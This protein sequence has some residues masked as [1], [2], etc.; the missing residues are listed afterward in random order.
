M[1]IR[2]YIF[3]GALLIAAAIIVYIGIYPRIKRRRRKR[4]MQTSFPTEWQS[5]LINDFPLYQMLPAPVQNNL[6]EKILVFLAEKNFVGCNGL[7]LTLQ[8]KVCIAAQACLLIANRKNDFYNAL[9]TILVYPEAFVVATQ[10]H[11]GDGLHIEDKNALLGQSWQQ[12]KV[13]V[14]WQDVL[15]GCQHATDGFNVSYHEFAHQLDQESGAA[16]GAPLLERH[17]YERW[18]E[19]LG[20]E[21]KKLQQQVYRQQKSLIDQY[22]ATHPAEFFAVVSEL[23]LERPKDLQ[24]QHKELYDL[25]NQFYKLDPHEWI[26]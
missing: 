4:L 18:P 15:Y 19:I 3:I 1:I 9:K 24:D 26:T 2:D 21:Y 22:G 13:I 8:M 7:Q 23:Y 10:T 16:N 12:G 25:L 11:I 20:L 5:I 17:L 6:R 14:S